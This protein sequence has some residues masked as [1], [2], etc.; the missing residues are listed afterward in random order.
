[1]NHENKNKKQKRGSSQGRGAQKKKFT[2]FAM[3]EK[4]LWMSFFLS[5]L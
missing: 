2:D 5:E 3:K 1:M 4:R